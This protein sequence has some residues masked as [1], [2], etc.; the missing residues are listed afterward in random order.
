MSHP[1]LFRHGNSDSALYDDLRTDLDILVEGSGQVGPDSGG[2]SAFS[3]RAADW[4]AEETWVLQDSILLVDGLSAKHTHGNHWLIAPARTMALVE[5]QALLKL[6]N[7]SSV[8]L[9]RLPETPYDL[10][11]EDHR[12]HI[13]SRQ[14]YYAMATLLRERIAIPGWH[15]NDY[16]YV[17]S[18]A[19]AF[20]HGMVE[21]SQLAGDRRGVQPPWSRESAFTKRA[22]AAY[23]DVLLKRARALDDDDHDD[24]QS[25]VLN[26][27]SIIASIFNF[28][29]FEY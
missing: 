18:V 5:Y 20:R 17:A 12:P 29:T 27:H 15:A 28:D 16:A 26:D 7:I 14:A 1:I 8:R 19:D 11:K 2:V 21:L 25:D 13:H 4:T 9:D 10:T 24:E 6:L 22:V 3:Q 23:M